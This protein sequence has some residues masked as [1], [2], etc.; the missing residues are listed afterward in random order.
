[1][2]DFIRASFFSLLILEIAAAFICL[3]YGYPHPPAAYLH[4]PDYCTYYC[5]TTGC[6]HRLGVSP[7]HPVLLFQVLMLW[8]LG[9]SYEGANILVY[10]GVLGMLWLLS[11]QYLL[12]NFPQKVPTWLGSLALPGLAIFF[13]PGLLHRLFTG[14]VFVCLTL[15]RFTHQSLYDIYLIGFGFGIPIITVVLLGSV[16]LKYVWYRY[17]YRRT[18]A[19][20]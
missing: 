3:Q 15:A 14:C 1:M 9:G 18:V 16:L 13:W 5:E 20:S 2:S 7:Y 12:G 11:I 17:V 8:S 19:T 6:T 10:W 4:N